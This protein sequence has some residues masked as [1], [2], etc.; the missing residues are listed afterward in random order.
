VG[1]QAGLASV[2]G[3][4]EPACLGGVAAQPLVFPAGPA[5]E[6]FVDSFQ[7]YFRE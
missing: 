7:T 3:G 2:D 5:N 6:V 1:E 4:Q